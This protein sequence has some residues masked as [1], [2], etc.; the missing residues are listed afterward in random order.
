MKDKVIIITGAAMG[1]GLV[2]AKE[3]DAK[4]AHLTLVDYNEQSL[5]AAKQEISNGFPGVKVLTVVADVSQE[6]AVKKYVDETVQTFGR[7]D[8]FYNNAGI[9]GRQAGMTE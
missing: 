3:L 6:E 4:G 9:E 5:S 1:L 8:G 2:A 7:I